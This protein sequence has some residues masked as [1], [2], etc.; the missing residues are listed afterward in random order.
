[1]CLFCNKS[2]MSTD[3]FFAAFKR[4]IARRGHCTDVYSDNGSNF[5]SANRELNILKK[6]FDDEK[7]GSDVKKSKSSPKSKIYI[8]IL[9]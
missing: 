9:K 8:L 7:A 1:M 6:L 3:A 2:D 4:F 5:V